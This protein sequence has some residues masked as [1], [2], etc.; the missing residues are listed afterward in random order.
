MKLSDLLPQ[1]TSFHL[2]QLDEDLTLRPITLADEIWL[3]ETFGETGVS[4]M[5]S[6]LNFIEIS[7]V[8]YR[9]LDD[10]SKAKL[11]KKKVT[12]YNEDG[13]ESEHEI[14]GL[15]LLQLSISGIAE[16]EA[17]VGGLLKCLGFTEK[18][19]DDLVDDD[20]EESKKKDQ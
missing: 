9:L 5:F 11:K 1:S 18:M 14:G 10:D 15:K 17:I 13:E 12:I 8:V 16:K 19:I 20:Q 4:E 2:S 3:N 7:R 6:T